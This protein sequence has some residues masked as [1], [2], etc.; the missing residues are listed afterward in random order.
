[1]TIIPLICK[2]FLF[3]MLQVRGDTLMHPHTRTHTDT[4]ILKPTSHTVLLGGL[5]EISEGEGAFQDNGGV[6]Q[7]TLTLQPLTEAPCLHCT[8]IL[9]IKASTNKRDSKKCNF[10][11]SD[12]SPADVLGSTILWSECCTI[13]QMV[14][15]ENWWWG[16]KIQEDEP[17]S[18]RK[19]E[20]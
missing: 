4:H 2:L 19:Y 7:N 18:W 12:Q 5:E 8:S 11:S 3:F 17:L 16:M 1:M 13:Y 20:S 15:N 6:I 9:D 14:I 10:H